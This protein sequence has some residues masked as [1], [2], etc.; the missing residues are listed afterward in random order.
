MSSSPKAPTVSARSLGKAFKQALKRIAEAAAIYGE[1]QQRSKS[2]INAAH[3]WAADYAHELVQQELKLV[4]W[5]VEH[6][7]D[8]PSAITSTIKDRI[9][10]NSREGRKRR[11]L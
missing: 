10:A 6:G 1:D 3:R 9:E 11:G 4:L 8:T 2:A 7:D 5:Q